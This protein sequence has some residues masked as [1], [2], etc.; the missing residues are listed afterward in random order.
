MADRNS[1]QIKICGMR[2]IALALDVLDW[3]ADYIGMIH[4]VRSPRHVSLTEMTSLSS[5]LPEG[6]RVAVV[7]DPEPTLVSAIWQTGVDHLQVHLKNGS[8]QRLEQL[9]ESLPS[10]KQLWLAPSWPPQHPF[11]SEILPFASRV[12]VDTYVPHQV[13]GTGKTGDWS[14]FRKLV[15]ANPTMPF[16]LAGG[17]H[18]ENVCEAIRLSGATCIDVNSGVEREPGVKCPVKLRALFHAVHEQC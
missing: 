6:T 17:L 4:H 16:V 12:V 5:N 7:V 13:G 14:G 1:I 8:E 18:P 11:P 9:Q 3:G 10:G 2:D 15:I